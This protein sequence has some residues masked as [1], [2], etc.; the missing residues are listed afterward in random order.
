MKF[1]KVTHSVLRRLQAQGYNVLI[2]PSDSED[3]ENVTWKAIA[4]PN[5]MD[6]L[7]ALDCEGWTNIPFQEPHILLIEE[8]LQNIENE[9]LFG[10]VFIENNMKTLQDYRNEV[11]DY[12]EKLYL[13]NAAIRTGD[14]SKYET[15]L[16]IAFPDRI[17][18]ELEEVRLTT[19]RVKKMTKDELKIWISKNKINLI[20]TDLYFLDEGSIITGEK[21]INENLQFIIGDGIED[22]IDCPVSPND[23][24]KLTDH[25]FY[26]VDSLIKM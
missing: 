17:S 16:R 5:V 25:Q 23:I 22:I 1:E 8:A 10:S 9:E 2:A 4:V 19:D 14:V 20:T 11:G 21:A 18:E 24:L 26:F 6:W 3:D 13:R 12:G 15:F 7:V